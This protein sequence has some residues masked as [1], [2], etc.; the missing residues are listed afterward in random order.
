MTHV[1]QRQISAKMPTAVAGDG[2]YLIDSQGNR[3]LDASG[4]AAV[5]CL[6][7]NDRDVIEAIKAQVDELAFAH[8][9]F[10]T[11][12]PAEE[13]ADL[14][15]DAAPDGI[16]MVYFLSGGSEAIE[17]ALKMARQYFLETGEPKRTRFIA[18]EQ[19]YHGNT[20]GALSVGGNAWRREPFKE[21]LIESSHI[22]PCYP[23]RHKSPDET[24]EDYGR[25]TADALEAE[26]LRLGPETVAAFVAETVVGA[27][28]G[29]VPPVEGYFERIREIC[30]KYGVLLILDEVMCGMGR[31]GTLFACEQDGISP[32][33]ICVA[34]GLGAGY[35]PIGATLVTDKI[36]A[37]PLGV[38]ALCARPLRREPGVEPG[39]P[40]AVPVGNRRHVGPLGILRIRAARRRDGNDG[41]G[42]GR[43]CAGWVRE[44][45][46]AQRRPPGT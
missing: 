46:V 43:T 19:S 45:P 22:A 6:G 5:S 10:F 31:T 2:V 3:Y 4:G 7:H 33:I 44:Q 9:A 1:F 37:A 26:I 35:Q 11:S 8:T 21:M 15:I 39:R 25:R 30:D 13:L 32:D 20:I 34:K 24:D 36:F 41:G 27:T 38:R 12:A 42:A 17:A 40:A 14:L 29:V 23:Y 18:R 28:A 16:A